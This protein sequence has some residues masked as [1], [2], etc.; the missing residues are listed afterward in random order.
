MD[1]PSSQ[2]WIFEY[3]AAVTRKI[4]NIL[5]A[6]ENLGTQGGRAALEWLLQNAGTA[7]SW[8]R[9][10]PSELVLEDPGVSRCHWLGCILILVFLDGSAETEGLNI[11]HD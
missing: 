3:M 5:N 4:S 1:K 11:R 2:S 6:T 7:C 10:T 9:Y 8:P